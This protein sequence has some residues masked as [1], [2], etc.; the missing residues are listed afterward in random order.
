[1]SAH[2]TEDLTL[3]Y[4]IAEIGPNFCISADPQANQERLAR[5]IDVACVAGANAIKLQLKSL[6]G[7][8]AKEDLNKPI[9]DPLSPFRTRGEFVRA[10][11]PDAALL[12]GVDAYCKSRGLDWSAS[13]WDVTSVHLLARFHPPWVKVASASLT[14]LPLL[15]AIRAMRTHV[16]LSTGM[17]T[18]AEVDAA[19]DALGSDITILH[20]VSTYPAIISEIDLKVME[21]L[22]DRYG[23]Q[24]GWSG[25]ERGIGTSIA[26]ASVG[27][28]VIERHLTMDPDEWGPDHRSSLDPAGFISMVKG[29][30]DARRTA[31]LGSGLKVV[32]P[33]EVP[34]RERLRR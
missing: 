18:E 21:T 22:R 13:P 29:V 2:F 27:A 28:V 33:S 5:L 32:A 23:C 26:A 34:H 6:G 31:L 19:V 8:Y 14:D 10:R 24:V 11:E 17:S 30:R 20:C 15:A 16:I 25:H 12:T 3:P 7:Y 9:T 1:M 4:V